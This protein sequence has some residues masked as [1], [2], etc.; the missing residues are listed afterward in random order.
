MDSAPHST[1]Q[2]I[3]ACCH[4]GFPS[5]GSNRFAA[6]V[7]KSSFRHCTSPA[8]AALMVTSWAKTRHRRLR[9]GR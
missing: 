5:I 4:L 8:M 6:N 7:A 9:Y 1:R 3:A 2:A